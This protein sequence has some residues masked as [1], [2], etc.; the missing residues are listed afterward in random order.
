MESA[1]YS[2]LL[3]NVILL[4]GLGVIYDTL[5]LHGFTN[6]R[7][8]DLLS[9]V[10]VGGI[11]IAVMATPW[12]LEKGIFFDTR[13][14]L[15][16][17]CGL[18]F[19]VRTTLIAAG[20]AVA[21]RLYQGGGGAIVGSIVIVSTA[22]I[23]LIWRYTSQFVKTP[24]KWQYLYLF[25]L[26]VQL[27]VAAC[28]LLMPVEM[29]HTLF[30]K[31]IPPILILFPIVTML[32]GLILRRQKDRRVAERDLRNSQQMLNRE[33]GLLRGLI[34]SIPD[35]VFVKDTDHKYISC[36]KAFESFTN[37]VEA[38]VL[39]KEDSELFKPDV[40]KLVRQK[41]LEV[42]S[43]GS[44][45]SY[46]CVAYYP[47]GREVVLDVYKA[48][49][50]SLD[51]TLHG[52]M[53]ISRDITEKRMADKLI[54]RQANYDA[55]TGL[56][57]RN[58]M[59]DRM[60]Q[61]M[62]KAG[63]SGNKIGLMFLDLD[64]FKEVN[65]TLGH[66]MGDRLLVQA[67]E[68][69]QSA[70]RESDTVARQG[71]DEFTVILSDLD[72]MT[73]VERIAA[74]ILLKLSEP[75]N[76]SGDMAYVTGSI[77]I[78]FFP[79]DA[80]SVDQLVKNADQAMYAAKSLGRNRFAYFTYSMQ[81]A[82]LERIHLAKD[83]RM[84]CE[85]QQFS[86]R[87]QPIID[88]RSGLVCKAEALIRWHHPERGFVSPLDFI[89][90]A[91]ETGHIPEIGDWVFSQA[92]RQVREW[93]KHFHP[94]FQVSINTSPLQF[95][96]ERSRPEVWLR[97]LEK[98]DLSGDALTVEITEGLLMES[99]AEISEKLTVFRQGGVQIALD[100]FGTGYSSLAYLR[101]FDI[102]YL[103]ID[104]AF[105]QNLTAESDDMALCEA[106]VVM[107]H[108]LGLF[109]VAEGVETQEQRDL[110]AGVGCDYGQGYYF[111]Q[112]MDA[113]QFAEYWQQTEL[114]ERL[115]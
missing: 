65:D 60:V 34:D 86:L 24:L 20:M 81:Q 17:L 50:Y 80:E 18:F 40:A 107:A 111:A 16:S 69:I 88:L 68:R 90:V 61:E 43:S 29:H 79:D 54:W 96:E 42:M 76:L 110:L 97:A 70:V 45:Q 22:S 10:L 89:P 19:G 91:E 39:Q 8:R 33:R 103:K 3:N 109:V 104:K 49:F 58:M 36:N 32:M 78:T 7:L 84:A 56:P 52:V 35:L 83:L 46:E 99:S 44:A 4:L 94:N 26:V 13:W 102:D 25:G 72:D 100:D 15:I 108:K 37:S 85:E 30:T 64:R 105:V 38:E 74:N 73:C 93:R 59:R 12:E 53:G 14:I 21:F 27:D 5:G 47:D 48:P 101:R 77:G 113:A 57:N 71:G 63:R 75:F 23:G 98:Q 114:P 82:A 41:D 9:G 55:L 28:L 1:S 11:A 67:A 2:A 31:V 87:Y 6:K 112:P 51:G 115:S 106:I 95:M 66:D 62:K 92:I